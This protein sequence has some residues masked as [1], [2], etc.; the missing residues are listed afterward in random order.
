MAKTSAVVPTPF[1]RCFDLLGL[2]RHVGLRQ[3]HERSGSAPRSASARAASI[4][5]S[6]AANISAVQP[7]RG[8]GEFGPAAAR[9]LQ[10]RRV[11]HRRARVDVGARLRPATRRHRR[12]SRPR[13]TSAPSRRTTRSRALTLAPRA[14]RRLHGL[15]VAGARR[16]HQHRLAFG[17]RVFGVGAGLQQRVDR[18]RRCRWSRPASAA[19]RRSG[20]RPWRWRPRA[21]SMRDQ[22]GVVRLHGPVQRRRAVGLGPVDV[23]AVARAACA[24]RRGRRA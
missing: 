3:R 16:R 19:A 15:D 23:G 14:S 1:G 4:A 10:H 17:G 9:E 12:G 22:L 20:W 5:P 8:N 11:E 21:S 6:R 2:Q 7:P 13:P 24:R 18:P